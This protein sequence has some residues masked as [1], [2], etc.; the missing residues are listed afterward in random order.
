MID[1]PGYYECDDLEQRVNDVIKNIRAIM[2]LFDIKVFAYTD[3]VEIRGAIPLQLLE[4]KAVK[5][6]FPA[7]VIS[8]AL[9]WQRGSGEKELKLFLRDVHFHRGSDGLSA[10]I[11]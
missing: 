9:R 5:K 1:P 2:Q 6:S 8:S 11:F 10:D 7:P 3:H 4:M